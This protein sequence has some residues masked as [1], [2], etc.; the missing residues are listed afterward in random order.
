MKGQ[1]TSACDIWAVGATAIELFTGHP[2][3]HN[4][5]AMSALFRIVQDP[6]P[7]IPANASQLFKQFLG[8]CFTKD[9][10]MRPSAKTLQTHIW[11]KTQINTDSDDTVT[12][13]NESK[14]NNDK[15]DS[16]TD[17]ETQGKAIGSDAKK[18]DKT[19]ESVRSI[20]ASIIS[21][22]LVVFGIF[23]VYGC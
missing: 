5:Q 1:A 4:L 2:P 19:V 16:D 21:E 22:F 18:L 10:S 13:V 8:D 15:E 6:R 12:T 23:Y 14:S 3:Y 20:I 7:D 11:L 9:P 17:D